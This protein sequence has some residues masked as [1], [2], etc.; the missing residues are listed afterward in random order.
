MP[1]VLKSGTLNL[2][3]NSGP[4]QDCNGIVLPLTLAFVILLLY[5]LCN[6]SHNLMLK[7]IIRK[8]NGKPHKGIINFIIPYKNNKIDITLS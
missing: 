4:V 6:G 2:L 8:L 5:E 7:Y 3:E 1:I